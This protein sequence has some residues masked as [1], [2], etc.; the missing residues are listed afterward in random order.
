[1]QQKIETLKSRIVTCRSLNKKFS[2]VI[3]VVHPNN[4]TTKTSKTKAK[5]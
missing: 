1:M 3:I 4:T 2:T 5:S